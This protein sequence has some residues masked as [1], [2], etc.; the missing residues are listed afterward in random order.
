MGKGT[1][2]VR[3]RCRAAAATIALVA[4]VAAVSAQR[5]GWFIESRDHPAIEYSTGALSNP[6]AALNQKLRDGTVEL[7]YEPIN[8]YLGSVLD[9]LRI[10]RESQVTVFS[11]TS[12]Q[13][14]KIKLNNPRTLYF[15]D[16]TSIGWV[17]NGRVL[18]VATLDATQ[19]VVFYMLDDEEPTDVPQFERNDDCLAC[20]LTRDTLGVPGLVVYSVAPLADAKAYR[21]ASV[22]DHRSPLEERWGGWYVTGGHGIRH[23]GNVPTEGVRPDARADA[24][25]PEFETLADARFDLEG[26]LTPHSDIAALMLLEHQTHMTNLLTRM[27]WEARVAPSAPDREVARRRMRDTASELVD[28]LLFVDETPLTEVSGR[29][30]GASGFAEVFSAGG[31]HDSEGRSLRQLDLEDRLLRY[32]CSYMIYTAAFDALPADALDLVYRRMWEVLSG[33][34][35]APRY[36]GLSR[37]DR[38]AVVDILRDTKPGLPAYFGPVSR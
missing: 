3:R 14:S 15:N 1:V 8:G 24:P 6:V 21:S 22:I 38:Q 19:G 16:D 5:G 28:Y 29:L 13:A 26:Y 23:K 18:E 25:T 37:A 7:S 33:D 32:P 12:F 11:P 4:G 27:G 34:E 31:P 2:R 17:R 9:A 10:P 30:E 36:A 20:H 35:D